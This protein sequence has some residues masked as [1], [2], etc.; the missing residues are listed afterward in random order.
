MLLFLKNA[1]FSLRVSA[2]CFAV[3]LDGKAYVAVLFLSAV[4]ANFQP[5]ERCLAPRLFNMPHLREGFM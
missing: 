4:L 5:V 2:V 3:C 1:Y